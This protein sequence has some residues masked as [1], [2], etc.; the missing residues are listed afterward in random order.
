MKKASGMK[1]LPSIDLLATKAGTLRE[2]LCTGACVAEK[3]LGM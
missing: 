1:A 2:Y 3:A